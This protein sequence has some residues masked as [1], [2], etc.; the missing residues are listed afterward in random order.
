MHCYQNFY[1][2]LNMETKKKGVPQVYT[3]EKKN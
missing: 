2:L 3:E 1:Q